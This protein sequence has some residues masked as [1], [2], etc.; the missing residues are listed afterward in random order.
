M[1]KEEFPYQGIMHSLYNKYPNSN[2]LL[3][4]EELYQIYQSETGDYEEP[5]SENYQEFYGWFIQQEEDKIN[6]IVILIKL[7]D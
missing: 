6:S 3:I 4:Y 7:R 2:G 5:S 1:N